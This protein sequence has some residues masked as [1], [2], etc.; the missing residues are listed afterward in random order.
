MEYQKSHNLYEDQ[1]QY[2][3]NQA[4]FDL[5]RLAREM[6]I[7]RVDTVLKNIVEEGFNAACQVIRY[8]LIKDLDKI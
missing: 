6:K 4:Y 5:G 2:C 1:I 3:Q 7:F 8:F